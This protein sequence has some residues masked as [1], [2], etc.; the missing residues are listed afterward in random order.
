MTL[1]TG[2]LATGRLTFGRPCMAQ[3]RD[4]DLI[5][6]DGLTRGLRWNRLTTTADAL[7]IDPPL[8]GP[9]LATAAS[10]SETYYCAYR[11]MDRDNKFSSIS[12]LRTITG[13]A[14]DGTVGFTWSALQQST[15]SRIN[16]MQLY[17]STTT[18]STILYPIYGAGIVPTY[19]SA[20]T[21]GGYVRFTT[22]AAHGFEVGDFVL[23]AGF[24]PTEYNGV[25]QI[26]KTPSTTTFTLNA[27]YVS[28]VTV[29][30]TLTQRVFNF[31]HNGTW[32]SETDGGGSHVFTV[33]ESALPHRLA[34]G[35]RVTIASHGVAGMNIEHTVTA[36]TRTTFTVGTALAAADD[37]DGGTWT[38]TGSTEGDIAGAVDTNIS[39]ADLD[40]NEGLPV[41]NPDST[42]HA[43]RFEPPPKHKAVCTMFQDR[44]WYAVDVYYTEG[45]L[46]GSAASRT[47]TGSSTN[48]HSDMI[49]R[50]VYISTETKPFI[51]QD[52][53]STTSLVVERL[54]AGTMTGVSYTIAPDPD[55]RNQLY[56]SEVDEP[57]SVPSVNT[58]IAQEN[59][60]DNDVITGLIPHGAVMYVGKERHMYRLTFEAQPNI[61][62]K[63]S[64]AFSRGL[65]NNRCWTTFED[66][67]YIMDQFGIYSISLRGSDAMSRAGVTDIGAPIQD[68]LNLVDFTYSKNFGAIADPERRRILFFVYLTTSGPQDTTFPYC[69]DTPARP[70]AALVFNVDTKTWDQFVYPF[71]LGGWSLAELSGR[72]RVV[73]GGIKDRVY[74][75]DSQSWDVANFSGTVTGY[76]AAG[77]TLTDSAAAFTGDIVNAP[78]LI[79][80]GDGKFEARRVVS[81]TS[82]VLTLNAAFTATLSTSGITQSKYIVGGVAWK[83]QTGRFQFPDSYDSKKA[84]TGNKR[85]LRFA[86]EPV[87][88]TSEIDVRWWMNHDTSPLTNHADIKEG[89]GIRIKRGSADTYVDFDRSRAG[90]TETPGFSVVEIGCG[91]LHGESQGHRWL[92]TE[93]RGVAGPVAH[94]IYSMTLMGVQPH[95]QAQG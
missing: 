54:P 42:L 58:V 9:V 13:D 65:L 57:E 40:D 15:Q 14:V 86:W 44:M 11:Y 71:D 10:G 80:D 17:R 29:S 5:Y 93:L 37:N 68:T 76:N 31:G 3:S 62:A 43:R 63:C 2:T 38:L 50:L 84:G 95:P 89:N 26:L 88:G 4:L 16:R 45:T 47:L 1:A 41:T 48:W 55:E 56:Y 32:A 53:S 27:G 77:P 39:D 19:S 90:T 69:A 81:A 36:V 74:K 8:A 6:T 52:V 72:M 46:S 61:D 24:T 60:V 67:A 75:M 79:Y 59:V 92:S 34:Q 83:F 70:R 30:G 12:P 23:V 94:K 28:A 25:W 7:G 18:E 82:T 73:M 35:C 87:D 51:I 49:G 91:H 78:V 21:D 64:L 85:G 33:A 66:E 20:A 22:S